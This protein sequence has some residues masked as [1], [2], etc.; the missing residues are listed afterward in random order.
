MTAP[1]KSITDIA[2][3]F[4]EGSELSAALDVNAPVDRTKDLAR[5]EW[6]RRWLDLPERRRRRELHLME[7]ELYERLEELRCSHE[8]A[9]R[10]ANEALEASAWANNFFQGVVHYQDPAGKGEV[11][12]R[13]TETR[14]YWDITL[15]ALKI[16]ADERSSYAGAEGAVA[17]AHTRSQAARR[18]Y[19]D[20][21]QARHRAVAWTFLLTLVSIA[22]TALLMHCGLYTP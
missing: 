18:Y 1:K 9:E 17:L 4:A 13:W 7:R 16:A 19:A 3:D 11:S 6:E 21:R 2:R 20:L 14:S 15:Q 10:S 22:A 5:D 8:A 12:R